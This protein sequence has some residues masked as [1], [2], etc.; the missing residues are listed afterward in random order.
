MRA[1]E[2]RKPN[3][4]KI[5]KTTVCGKNQLGGIANLV[6]IERVNCVNWKPVA[7]NI[8]QNNATNPE[9]HNYNPTMQNMCKRNNVNV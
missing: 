6:G 8:E 1:C 9:L 4:K 3:V 7:C 5:N 2:M